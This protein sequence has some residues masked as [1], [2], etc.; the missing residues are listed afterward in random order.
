MR[1]I[2]AENTKR[3]MKDRCLQQGAIAKKA[4]YGCQE[5]SNMMHGRKLIKDTDVIRI[6][7]ALGTDANTLLGVKPKVSF[8]EA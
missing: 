3:I 2:V 5:F 7:N 1:S 8:E 4:G 6:A